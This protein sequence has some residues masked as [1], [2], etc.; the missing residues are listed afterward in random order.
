[1][2][3]SQND[4]SASL[5][6]P[7]RLA[8]HNRQHTCRCGKHNHFVSHNSPRNY[9]IY[10]CLDGHLTFIHWLGEPGGVVHSIKYLGGES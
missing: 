3:S 7:R 1:M 2:R 9:T 6:P 4:T 10:E 8:G 5:T